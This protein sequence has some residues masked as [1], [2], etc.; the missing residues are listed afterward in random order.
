MA[1]LQTQGISIHYELLGDRRNPP[2]VLLHG[3]GGSGRSWGSQVERFAKN[4]FVVLPDQRG[5]GQS[6]R[7]ETG[8]AIAQMELLDAMGKKA[9]TYGQLAVRDVGGRPSR[10]G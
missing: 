10:R 6:T 1:T 5:T 3:L 2:V 9:L 4:H 7:S 8:Y